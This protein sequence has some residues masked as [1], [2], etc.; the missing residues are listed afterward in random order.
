M[1]RTFRGDARK[2]KQLKRDK[3]FREKRKSPQK[4]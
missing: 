4:Y 1:S 2:K 3:T